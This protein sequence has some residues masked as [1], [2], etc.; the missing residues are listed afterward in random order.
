MTMQVNRKDLANSK[1]QLTIIADSVELNEYKQ[2]VLKELAKEVQV[3]GFRDGKAP[4]NVVEKHVDQQRLQAEVVEH[5]INHLYPDAVGQENLRPI[6]NPQVNMKKFVPYT[7]LEFTA[8]VEVLGPVKLADYKK[9]K[10]SL[11]K[12]TVAA[13][14]I[15]EVISSLRERMASSKEVKRAAEDGDK[16]TIDFKGIDAKQKPVKGADG[17][18][19]PLLL[20]SDTFIP[21]FEKNLVG[22]KAGDTKIF[23]LTFPK[24][25]GVKALAGSKVAFTV[26]VKKVEE[27]SL[28]EVDDTF[29][30][31]AGPFKTLQELKNSI[32][33]ELTRERQAQVQQ[34]LEAEIIKEV[35]A[36][37]NLRVPEALIDDQ[38]QRLQTELRQN[39]TYRGLT[40]QEYLEREGKTEESYEIDVL[41]PEAEE[42]VKAGLV[43]AEIS[44][45]E[46][47]KVTPEELEMRMQF[48]K[49]Q[50]Q[51]PAMQAELDKPESRQNI[52]NRLLTEKTIQKLVEYA[53]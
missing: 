40:Y 46:G 49:G 16:V 39:L 28:P 53:T 2:H 37:S 43:L 15:D 31:K 3:Q 12:V 9:I 10:K 4:L 24:D 27:Q 47:L 32:K 34:E 36:K 48:L 41:R 35:A 30:A 33:Q 26:T 11:A 6:D 45:K 44:E 42:R 8:E 38:M 17:K 23:E 51:D 7:N 52:A 29:A 19:Y 14:D 5:A 22:L 13:A 20:G 21:G 25:Y 50:Y 1:V 18:D